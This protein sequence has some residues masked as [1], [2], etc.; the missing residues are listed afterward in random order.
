MPDSSYKSSN[1]HI[2][3]RILAMNISHLIEMLEDYRDRYGEME[4]LSCPPVN[5]AA[6]IGDEC[7]TDDLN[8]DCYENTKDY[9]GNRCVKIYGYM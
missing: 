3:E 7:W 4:V 2:L 8:V 9:D 1:R 5:M 6:I